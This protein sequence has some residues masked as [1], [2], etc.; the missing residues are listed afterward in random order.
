MDE[1]ES[2][3]GYIELIFEDFDFLEEDMFRGLAEFAMSTPPVLLNSMSF[4]GLDQ[5]VD[6]MPGEVARR[7][8]AFRTE[9]D[10]IV[11]ADAE[12]V[13]VNTI[14]NALNSMH[15]H[16]VY[17]RDMNEVQITVGLEN[18]IEAGLADMYDI[19]TKREYNIG[20]A[21]KRSGKQTCISIRMRMVNALIWQYWRIKRLTDSK[22]S[23]YN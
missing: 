20:L 7:Y 17:Y 13:I 3:N 19:H 18:I 10:E 15:K 12:S 9:L 4:K 1:L 11:K 22:T 2:C 14:L 23:I 6:V 16:V 8:T 21:K 5:Y